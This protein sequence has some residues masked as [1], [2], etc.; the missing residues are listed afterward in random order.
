LITARNID[1]IILP[2][3]AKIKNLMAEEIQRKG[4]TAILKKAIQGVEFDWPR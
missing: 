3:R 2:L 1:Q 4:P